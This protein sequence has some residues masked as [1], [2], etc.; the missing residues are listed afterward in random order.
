[1]SDA[2]ESK[3]VE[4]RNTVRTIEPRPVL[5]NPA[6]GKEHW[7]ENTLLR[8]VPGQERRL[9]EDHLERIDLPHRAILQQAE[10]KIDYAYFPTE[11]L[12]SLLILTRDGRSVEVGVVG[13]EG[14]IGTPLT[15]QLRFQPCRAI[16]QM[17]G[18]G[19]RIRSEALEETLR[20]APELARILSRYVLLQGLQVAQIAACN[21]LHE[22][23]QRLARWLLMCQDRV[24]LETFPVTHEALAQMLGTGRPSVTLAAAALQRADTILNLR[25]TVKILKR[26]E[27]E[28]AACECYRAIRDFGQEPL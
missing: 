5:L 26:E 14:M 9:L 12:V 22:V 24:G 23:E 20:S 1:M 13:S 18:K 10:N 16:V 3:Y 6:S 21:R 8:A 19:F 17:P 2:S 11:G 4:L 27:L 25:G 28:A 15:V 7:L